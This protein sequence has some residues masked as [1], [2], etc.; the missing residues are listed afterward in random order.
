[1]RSKVQDKYQKCIASILARRRRGLWWIQRNEKIFLEIRP[2]CQWREVGIYDEKY[3]T[4]SRTIRH[5]LGQQRG[6]AFIAF[7]PPPVLCSWWLAMLSRHSVAE[8]DGID[9]SSPARE[10]SLLHPNYEFYTFRLPP[11]QKTLR[12]LVWNFQGLWEA[13]EGYKRR[14]MDLS[15]SKRRLYIWQRVPYAQAF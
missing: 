3:R 11:F 2:A 10:F 1:M 14:I 7:A 6:K 9:D 5:K 8:V 12:D 4:S 15:I 13:I